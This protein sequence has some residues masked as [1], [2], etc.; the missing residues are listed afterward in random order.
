[1]SSGP[2]ED[3]GPEASVLRAAEEAFARVMAGVPEQVETM[4]PDL[5]LADAIRWAGDRVTEL[6][7]SLSELPLE[8]MLGLEE[9]APPPTDEPSAAGEPIHTQATAG[10]MA[11]ARVW[12]HPVGEL[13]PGTLHFLLSDLVTAGGDSIPGSLARFVPEQLSTP[14]PAGAATLLRLPVPADAAPGQYHGHV[15]AHGTCGAAV[16]ITVTLR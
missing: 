16:P 1:M 13:L 14:V 10:T 4:P 6:L 11:E 15:F 3:P 9:P 12:V 2:A 8:A 5:D 7:A